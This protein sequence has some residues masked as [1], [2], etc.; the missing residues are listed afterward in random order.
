MKSILSFI[1]KAFSNF[2]FE[3]SKREASNIS[4]EIALRTSIAAEKSLKTTA[5]D[6]TKGNDLEK[7]DITTLPTNQLKPALLEKEAKDRQT[8]EEAFIPSQKS[9][10]NPLP[11]SLHQYDN[12][13]IHLIQKAPQKEEP[14]SAQ[15]KTDLSLLYTLQQD[16]IEK[17]NSLIESA[18]KTYSFLL[19]LLNKK[20]VEPYE[21]QRL[22]QDP[23]KFFAEVQ[24][25]K[26][27]LHLF[28]FPFHSSLLFLQV[29]PCKKLSSEMREQLERTSISLIDQTHPKHTPITIVSIG[30]GGAYQELVYLAKLNYKQVTLILVD[31]ANVMV[32]ALDVFCKKKLPESSITIIKYNKLD[33]YIKEAIKQENLK[34]DLLL[35]LDLTDKKYEVDK[36]KLSDYAFHTLKGN[37]LVKNGS[38]IAYSTL[39]IVDSQFIP[40]AVCCSYDG[41]NELVEIK[42]DRREFTDS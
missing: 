22:R 12:S 9:L 1:D 41:S 16:I 28:H 27:E 7:K 34:P 2:T 15:Y 10:K 3:K 35:L 37:G 40:K 19:D 32:G 23:Y 18:S 26:K 21:I 14:P 36:Q 13:I 20:S 29:C 24:A 11:E 6:A 17:R 5:S 4:N 39:D 33:D 42:Q 8:A 30:P 25:A 38:I 31:P